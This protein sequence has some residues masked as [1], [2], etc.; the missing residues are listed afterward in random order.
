M[1]LGI[2]KRERERRRDRR[3]GK[4]VRAAEEEGGEKKEGGGIRVPRHS[5]KFCRLE[6]EKKGP[7]LSPG[8]YWGDLYSDSC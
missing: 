8:V 1:T 6:N 3:E 5:I 4:M 7:P 2:K